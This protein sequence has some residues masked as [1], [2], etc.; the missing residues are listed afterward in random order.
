MQW[1]HY[2]LFHSPLPLYIVVVVVE[3]VPHVLAAVAAV[4]RDDGYVQSVRP[5]GGASA[6]TIAGHDHQPVIS[7]IPTRLG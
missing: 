3:V 2:P 5:K 6:S 1:S 7:T 4:E